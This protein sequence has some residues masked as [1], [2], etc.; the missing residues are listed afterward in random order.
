VSLEVPLERVAA[1]GY[2]TVRFTRTVMCPGC[3]GYGTKT[4]KPPPSCETCSGTGHQVVE[5]RVRQKDG[6]S[7]RFEQI[8]NCPRCNGTGVIVGKPCGKCGGSGR[9]EEE[10]AV[11]VRIPPGIDD[12]AVLRIPGHGLP[13]GVA[14]EPG[15]LYVV[16]YSAPDPRFQRRGADLWRAVT[17]TVEDAV[18]GTKMIVPTLGGEVEVRIPRGVQPD[19]VL[20]LRGKGLPRPGN[21]TRGDLKLRLQVYI[22]DTTTPEERKLFE[23]LRALHRKH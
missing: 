12:G 2:E 13:G 23:Q 7:I 14:A 18:L 22:P 6:A 21:R 8:N 16:V 10:S 5:R 9:V 20:R 11:R 3:H 17:L 19:E 4:G 15:D 1:G